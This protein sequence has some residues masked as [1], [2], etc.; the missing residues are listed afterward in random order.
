MLEERDVMPAMKVPKML[1]YGRRKRKR[2]E[3]D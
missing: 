1:V 2:K 3:K